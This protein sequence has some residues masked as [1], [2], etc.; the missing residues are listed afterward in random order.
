[1]SP[2][3]DDELRDAASLLESARYSLVDPDEAKFGFYREYLDHNEPGL[4]FECLVRGADAQ[5]APRVVWEM[6]S[7]AAELMELGEEEFP[8]GPFVRVVVEHLRA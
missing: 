4:A 8:H 3:T 5:R 1:V 6:L 2:V 7:Q